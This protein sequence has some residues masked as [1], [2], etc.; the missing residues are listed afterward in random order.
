MKTRLPILALLAA[1]LAAGCGPAWKEISPAQGRFRVVLPGKPI[2]QDE[3]EQTPAGMARGKRFLGYTGAGG[4]DSFR[5]YAVSY[6][7]YPAG[8]IRAH[9]PEK[10]F[11]AQKDEVVPSEGR[12]L[13]ERPIKIG[14]APGIELEVE[15]PE[16]KILFFHIYLVERRLYVVTA[17]YARGKRSPE[18]D[19]FFDSFQVTRAGNTQVNR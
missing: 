6:I 4:T 1:A 13:N 7:D 9:P 10:I 3:S 18:V 12:L 15:D 11:A 17:K 2:E 16:G 5:A 8:Y 14:T 19:A